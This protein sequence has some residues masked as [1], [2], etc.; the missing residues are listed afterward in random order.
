M[1]EVESLRF[2]ISGVKGSVEECPHNVPEHPAAG[3]GPLVALPDAVVV[4]AGLAVVATGPCVVARG[5]AVV[6]TGPAVVA[7]AEQS[8][9]GSP[10]QAL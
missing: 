8:D 4:A 1:Q 7:T 10:L 2:R 9:A 6:A 5:P 3:L